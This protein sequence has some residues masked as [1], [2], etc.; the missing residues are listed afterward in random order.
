[1][2]RSASRSPG[3]RVLLVLLALI[4]ASALGYGAYRILFHEES[5]LESMVELPNYGT[6]A[7]YPAED[8]FVYI[9]G[10]RLSRRDAQAQEAFAIELPEQGMKASAS[11]DLMAVWSDTRLIITNSSGTVLQHQE[12]ATPILM[13]RCGSDSYAVTVWEDSQRVVYIY[14]AVDGSLV[15]RFLM[16]YQ[17]VLDMG[18]Y[19]SSLSQF[20]LL[21][22][23]SHYTVPSAQVKNV[24]PGKALTANISVSGQVVYA[25]APG[26]KAFY[27]VGTHAIQKWDATGAQLLEKSIYGWILLDM[28]TDSQENMQF[29]LGAASTEDTQTPLT[30]LWYISMAADGTVTEHRISLP[31]G[32]TQ[33]VLGDGRVLAFTQEG[34]Y[35]VD[36]RSGANKFYKTSQPIARVTGLSSTAAVGL[37]MANG[38]VAWMPVA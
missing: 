20:W 32:C 31:A 38:D 13:A 22:L 26:E 10:T 35:T 21:T 23:D 29:L 19:G 15:E 30:S 9:S 7:A 6:P 16:P 2:A 12:L 34:F 36:V 1:M 33:A 28:R 24:Q 18:F 11:R 4:L 8:G 37:E 5:P 3:R 27:T 17:S 14:K 25:V